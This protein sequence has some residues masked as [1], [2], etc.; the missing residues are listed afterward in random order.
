M[1]SAPS[2]FEFFDPL[3]QPSHE[4]LGHQLA[5]LLETWSRLRFQRHICAAVTACFRQ[6]FSWGLPVCHFCSTASVCPALHRRL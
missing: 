3:L 4:T 1:P 2:P 6:I 5:G